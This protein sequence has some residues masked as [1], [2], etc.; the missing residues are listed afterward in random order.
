MKDH[1]ETTISLTAVR[2]SSRDNSK[3]SASQLKFP[4]G[5]L[6][7]NNCLL[8]LGATWSFGIACIVGGGL[9]LNRTPS[10]NLGW[11]RLSMS[12]TLKECLPLLINIAVTALTEGTGFIHATT[13]RWAL[14]DELTFNSNLR[15]FSR[16]RGSWAFGGLSNF[17]NAA[18]LIL[19]YA[20]TS[21]IFTTVPPSDVCDALPL[22]GYDCTTQNNHKVAYV[23]PDA[24]M[25]LGVGLAGTA[26][27][28]TWQFFT[29]KVETWSSSPID[30]AWASVATGRRSRVDGRCMMSVHEA[31]L[32]AI[33]TVPKPRQQPAWTAQPEVRRIL[34]Y[35]WVLCLLVLLW[36]AA[37]FA[38]VE[39]IGR[40]CDSAGDGANYDDHCQGSYVGPSWS[41]LPDTDSLTSLA[42]LSPMDDAGGQSH[43]GIPKAAGFAIVFLMMMGFQAMLTMGLHC[44]DLLVNMSRD[45]DTWRKA[46]KGRGYTPRNALMTALGSWKPLLLFALKP[47]VH[48]FF[49]LGMTF[50]LGWGI[51]MRPP[52]ILY[53]SFAVLLV[54]LFGTYL[55]FEE[56]RGPQPAAF[57]HLQTLVDLVDDWGEP[58]F[59]GHKGG[60]GEGVS[61]AGTAR[62]ALEPVSM[63]EYYGGG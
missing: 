45:E 20:A 19:C 18:F 63:Q 25:A 61:R 57:G 43:S 38:S 2:S 60:K 5:L 11:F 31:K 3:E 33:P 62:S 46:S 7:R 6:T 55:C 4:R 15:L 48:W 24:I 40:Q 53:T 35:L 41:L 10:S 47:L 51:F 14:G 42:K 13:L 22:N 27:L 34:R 36:F 56:P 23:S 12:R 49:G 50:Y 32:P 29:S 58:M 9:Y 30:T 17:F 8:V 54:A 44:A 37:L 21:L 59:W 1:D 16:V 39:I 52:Q 26:A 28:T